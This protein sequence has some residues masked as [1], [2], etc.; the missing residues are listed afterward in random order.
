MEIGVFRA[1]GIHLARRGMPVAGRG[2][3][4]VRECL[5]PERLKDTG[6]RINLCGI[7]QRQRVVARPEKRGDALRISA[8]KA[9]DTDD[10]PI[11][12][13]RRATAIAMLH[14]ATDLDELGAVIVALERADIDVVDRRGQQIRR[15][16]VDIAIPW[17]P[18]DRQRIF[19]SKL[20]DESS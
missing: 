1:Q 6:L 17:E 5:L 2:R 13:E 19:D 8:A 20:A 18:D 9:D 15:I 3:G 16:A 11:D 12:I 4:I 14:I 7:R 10:A